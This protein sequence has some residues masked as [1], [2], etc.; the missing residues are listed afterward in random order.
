MNNPTH[1]LILVIDD[2]ED[3]RLLIGRLLENSGYKVT[4]AG[5]GIDALLEM[6]KTSFDLILADVNMPN[7]DGFKL[8]EMKTQ[9][10]IEGPVVFLT[11]RT[12]AED[13]KKGFELGAADYVKKPIQ[14]EILLLRVRNLLEKDDKR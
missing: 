7:L 12:S 5:D 3:M 9:K 11:S 1:P 2:D 13:E 6:G 4:L 10:G 14:K 8:L